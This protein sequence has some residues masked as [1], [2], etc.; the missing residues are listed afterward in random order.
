MSK[1]ASVVGSTGVV[2]GDDVV[3]ANHSDVGSGHD[4][5]NGKFA[6]NN[7]LIIKPQ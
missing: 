4:T 3:K 5:E 2:G 1:M 7:D 6:L